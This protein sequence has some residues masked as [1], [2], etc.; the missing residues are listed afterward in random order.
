L[1]FADPF[2]S[3]A[4]AL[5]ISVGLHK[6]ILDITCIANVG[7]KAIEA[8]NN[9]WAGIFNALLFVSIVVVSFFA[10]GASINTASK[11]FAEVS[12]RTAAAIF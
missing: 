9:A 6:S 10:L 3:I 5:S 8:P 1:V 7:I 2:I 4:L 11:T 12:T